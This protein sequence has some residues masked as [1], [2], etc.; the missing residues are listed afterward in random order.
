MCRHR[1]SG[2]VLLLAL[3]LFAL[4]TPVAWA[5]WSDNPAVNGQQPGDPNVD[6]GGAFERVVAS[7]LEFPI[8][9]AQGLGASAGLQ[10]LDKLIFLSG[11]SD[12]EKKIA[13]WVQGEVDFMKLWYAAMS[14]LALPLFLL[15][16]FASGIKLTTSGMNP[17]AREEAIQS[18]W[19]WF[20]ALAII[21]V[22]P[23]L[24][25]T[26][27]WITSVILDGIHFAFGLVATTAGIGRTVEDWGAIEF[28]GVSLTTGSVLGTAIVKCMF[29]IFWVWLNAIYI[30]R[31]LVLTVMFCFTPLMAVMWALNKN[32]TAM[33]VWMG[34]LASNAFMPV[35]HALVLCVILGFMDVKNV[36]QGG[37]WLQ[38]LIAIYTI[39]PLAEVIRN[40]LQSL[41]SRWA[42]VNEER[43]AGKAIAAAV[44]LGGVLSLGR[45]FGSTFGG[46]SGGSLSG[47][48]GPGSPA[49]SG[50]LNPIPVAG[51]GHGGA[52]V[53]APGDPGSPVAD[54]LGTSAAGGIAGGAGGNQGGIGDAAGGMAPQKQSLGERIS[55]VLHNPQEASS[56]AGGVARHTIGTGIRAVAGS[57]PGAAPLG[58]AVAGMAEGGARV[59]GATS[60]VW[61]QTRALKKKEKIPFGEALQKVTNKESTL[62]AVAG[63][64]GM[65][66][67][68]A[69]TPAPKQQKYQRHADDLDDR[70]R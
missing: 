26:M 67:N 47:P 5:G 30:V 4:A 53:P 58:D 37:T 36:S 24:V 38:I 35:A 20:G 7:L 45:V 49:G 60:A 27:M 65:V 59:A 63:A 23:L 50:N 69:F 16:I 29:V 34:E 12:D 46:S 14:G 2:A 11:A 9:I 41:M 62:A 22:A 64:A 13:P 55:S 42:G 8:K 44:G 70:R 6:Q 40:S 3:V 17:A 25:Q 33:A 51:G 61:A 48:G 56:L 43:T 1:Y 54:F 57:V 19:R 28:G 10:P 39:I 52:S 68:A 15:A 18:I 31:R 66:A 21:A 32:T